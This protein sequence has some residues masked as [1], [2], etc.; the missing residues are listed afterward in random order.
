MNTKKDGTKWTAILLVLGL[1][2]IVVSRFTG[3]EGLGAIG[4][5]L[6]IAAAISTIFSSGSDK[7]TQPTI[8]TSGTPPV[9]TLPPRRAASLP[10][11]P[12]RTAAPVR[13]APAYVEKRRE[14][15][16]GVWD[17]QPGFT[18]DET[19]LIGQWVRH[20]GG[21]SFVTEDLDAPM[22]RRTVAVLDANGQP[23]QLQVAVDDRGCVVEAAVPG[24]PWGPASSR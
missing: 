22:P 11:V 17:S 20:C 16:A 10:P 3:N 23:G 5:G 8:T 18:F 13:A 21:P 9:T 1:G 19:G 4:G 2:G 12:M 24:S 14:P 15:T 7:K 6:M